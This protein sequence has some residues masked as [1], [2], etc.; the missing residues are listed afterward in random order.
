M[1]RVLVAPPHRRVAAVAER[2][3]RAVLVLVLMPML[4]LALVLVLMPMRMR[5]RV[6]VLALVLMML[7]C[8][9]LLAW[10]RRERLMRVRVGRVTVRFNV[11]RVMMMIIVVA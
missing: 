1:S 6:L 5:G 8:R 7:V 3:G 4:V 2:R 9:R 11:W 10:W